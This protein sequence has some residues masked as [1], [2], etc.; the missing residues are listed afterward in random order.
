MELNE[1]EQGQVHSKVVAWLQ[2]PTKSHQNCRH[3][4]S[5]SRVLHEGIQGPSTLAEIKSKVVMC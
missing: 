5:H 1:P 2:A 4:T 3:Q